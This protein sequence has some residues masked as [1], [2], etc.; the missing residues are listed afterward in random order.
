MSEDN[1]YAAP[2]ADVAVSAQEELAG[3]GMRLGGA[4]IDGL[5]MIAI[6]MPVMYVSGY[7]DRAMVG[8]ET[9]TDAVLFAGLGMASFLV[10][11]GYLLATS[12]QTIGKRILGMRIVSVQ[13][14]KILSF[15]KVVSLR[16]LP[17]WV[18]SLIPIVGTIFSLLDALFIFREDRRCI[19]DLIAG[20]KVVNAGS[21]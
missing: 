17:V 14:D 5:I 2:E 15:G 6:I 3:R 7:W 11:Q 4:I 13:D 18:I 21:S 12:G 10:I 16:Y 20:T 9:V 8:Q 19:H 1:P